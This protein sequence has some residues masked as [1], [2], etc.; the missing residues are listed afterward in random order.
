MI[1]KPIAKA[2]LYRLAEMAFFFLL[3][4]VGQ[5]RRSPRPSRP[6]LISGVAPAEDRHGQR[7]LSKGELE[8]FGAWLQLHE[9]QWRRHIT[10]PV[11]P[12]YMVQLEHFDRSVTQ[13][14]FFRRDRSNVYF[15]KHE[16]RWG[17]QA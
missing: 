10:L 4:L 7:S 16:S 3:V 13:L 17:G 6:P 5:F 14:F 9:K 12:S 11:L 1:A 2:R 8:R 15:S